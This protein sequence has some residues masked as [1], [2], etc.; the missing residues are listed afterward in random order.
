MHGAHLHEALRFMQ[1][2]R[3][4]V[5]REDPGVDRPDAVAFAVGDKGVEQSAAD[6]SA[7]AL[8]VDIDGG[9]VGS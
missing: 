5:F 4:E 3:T 2:R 8:G 1:F 7:L 9:E 6:S